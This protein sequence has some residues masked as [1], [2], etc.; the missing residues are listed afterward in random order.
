MDTIIS[1]S[2]QKNS[3][4]IGER[5]RI[6]I[7]SD[8]YINKPVDNYTRTMENSITINYNNSKLS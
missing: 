2:N 5:S 7:S 6:I 4:N 1:I 3:Q 8:K